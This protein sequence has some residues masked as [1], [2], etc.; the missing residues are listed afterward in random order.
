MLGKLP[1]SI[2]RSSVDTRSDPVKKPKNKR[3]TAMHNSTAIYSKS[4]LEIKKR[5]LLKKDRKSVNISYQGHVQLACRQFQD[6]IQKAHNEVM[7]KIKVNSWWDTPIRI[8]MEAMGTSMHR[9]GQWIPDGHRN[10]TESNK[11]V[12]NA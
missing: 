10:M 12:W 1:K 7:K 11:Q 8:V 5:H 3:A 9:E 6:M 4:T 2:S